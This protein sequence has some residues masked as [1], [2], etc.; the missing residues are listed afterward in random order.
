M[1]EMVHRHFNRI[2]MDWGELGD[3]GGGCFNYP[4]EKG[5]HLKS[6]VVAWRWGEVLGFWIDSES[7]ATGSVSRKH[8]VDVGAVTGRGESRTLHGS[9]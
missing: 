2:P 7:P 8:R 4:G 1:R 3:Q 9:G 5:W 6:G